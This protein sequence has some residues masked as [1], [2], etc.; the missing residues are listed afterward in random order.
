[1]GLLIVRQKWGEKTSK[2]RC[3][4]ISTKNPTHTD[5]EDDLPLVA[6]WVRRRETRT[7]TKG[8]RGSQPHIIA[9]VGFLGL[10]SCG[11]SCPGAPGLGVWVHHLGA[12]GG[13][14]TGLLCPGARRKQPRALPFRAAWGDKALVVGSFGVGRDGI[15]YGLGGGLWGSGLTVGEE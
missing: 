15:C 13:G 5:F 1:M 6:W 8:R 7:Q 11:I 9:L 10:N 4:D 2:N 3:P 14:W 12:R